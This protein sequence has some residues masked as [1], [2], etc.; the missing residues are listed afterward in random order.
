MQVEWWGTSLTS[1]VCGRGWLAGLGTPT[2][3]ALDGRGGIARVWVPHSL[4]VF[5]EEVGRMVGDITFRGLPQSPAS[6][7]PSHH[8]HLHL[9]HQHNSSSCCCSVSQTPHTYTGSLLHFSIS[10]TPQYF[11]SHC[12]VFMTYANNSLLYTESVC[13]R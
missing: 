2:S 8:H 7:P 4:P 5:M 6:P 1:C 13:R 12:H 11:P 3:S 10:A 9:H